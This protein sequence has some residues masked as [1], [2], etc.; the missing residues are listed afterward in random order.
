MNTQLLDDAIALAG[1]LAEAGVQ[2]IEFREPAGGWQALASRLTDL[3]GLIIGANDGAELRWQG[4]GA[5]I[6]N[7]ALRQ[8]GSP[9]VFPP[10]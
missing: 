9:A 4:G 1:A 5:R 7:G 2:R 3:P 8:W 10:R 6:E